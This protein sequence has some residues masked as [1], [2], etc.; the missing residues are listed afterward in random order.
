MGTVKLAL[1]GLGLAA[2]FA[3]PSYAQMAPFTPGGY[4]DL[5]AGRGKAS[6][7]DVTSGRQSVWAARVGYRATPNFAVDAG[8]YDLGKYDLRPSGLGEDRATAKATSW[9]VSLVGSASIQAF[10]AY[11]RIGYARTESKVDLHFPGE[12]TASAKGHDNEAFYGVGARYNFGN[13]GVFVEW[14][15]HDKV[16]IDYYMAGLQLRF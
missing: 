7:E 16:D 9:G 8:Y 3:T 11:A 4:V 13:L 2:A 10:D 6:G 12:G 5:G 14:N 1:A 15:K